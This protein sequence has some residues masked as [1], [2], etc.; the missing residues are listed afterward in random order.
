MPASYAALASVALA[1]NPLL[2]GPLPPGLT[3]SLPSTTP[4]GQPAATSGPAAYL[5]GTSVGLDRPMRDILQ[6][7]RA[8]L[9]PSNRTLTWGGINPCLPYATQQLGAPAAGQAWNGVACKDSYSAAAKAGEGGVAALWPVFFS[10]NATAALA[11][12]VPLELRE[13]RTA[14]AISLAG[15]S[16]AGPLPGCWGQ[17]YSRTYYPSGPGFDQLT[18]LGLSSNALTGALPVALGAGLPAGA[19]ITLANNALS[20]QLPATLANKSVTITGN[21]GLFGLVP[22]GVSVLPAAAADGVVRTYYGTAIGLN[23]TLAHTLLAV[24]AGLD[25]TGALN[26]SWVPGTNPCFGAWSGVVCGE[27][28]AGGGVAALLLD[29]A[30]L[31][32]TLPCALL[33]LS[34]L[35][36][37]WLQGNRLSGGVPDL[38]PLSSLTSLRLGTNFLSGSL[39]AAYGSLSSRN[40]SMSVFANPQLCG[41]LPTPSLTLSGGIARTALNSSCAATRRRSVCFPALKPTGV[42]C[43]C[44]AAMRR[45]R[46]TSRT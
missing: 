23:D 26:S 21:S 16:L 5:Y 37:L 29:S 43:N 6:A 44:W 10:G 3:L 38:S 32:G 42:F 14:A 9:D 2:V 8:S 4:A 33:R 36:T 30:Q 15:H 11:G 31:N 20:G 22:S 35:Q 27:G 12:S 18:L 34:G 1:F 40:F 19:V 17:N 28:A 7:V 24:K 46:R 13:L 45:W 25:P 41:A 39:P